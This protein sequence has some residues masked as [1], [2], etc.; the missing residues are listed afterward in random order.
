MNHTELVADLAGK[1]G[2][3]KVDVEA[4]LHA[5]HTCLCEQLQSG[6]SVRVHNVG[7]FSPKSNP[8]R[9][10]QLP[11]GGTVS[12]PQS[13]SLKFSGSGVLKKALNT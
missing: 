10:Y 13:R 12:K 1:T 5:L 7:T 4:V 3:T 2:C 6:E 8:A 9:D 11:G